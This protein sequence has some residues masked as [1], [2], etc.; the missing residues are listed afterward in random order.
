MLTRV[1]RANQNL[2][3]FSTAKKFTERAEMI[4]TKHGSVIEKMP[5]VQQPTKL[6]RNALRPIS[7][8]DESSAKQMGKT[9]SFKI[10][11]DPQTGSLEGDAKAN[12][13]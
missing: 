10:D 4:A 2:R 11:T 5:S 6:N 7:V 8:Y 9:I 13:Q 1:A 12:L 3:M